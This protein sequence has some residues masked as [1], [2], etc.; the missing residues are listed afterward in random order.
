[1][2]GVKQ[3]G[4]CRWYVTRNGQIFGTPLSRQESVRRRADRLNAEARILVRSCLS[5]GTDF[6]SEGA[7][8][9]MCNPCRAKSEDWMSRM[10][11]SS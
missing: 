8:N 6:K 4:A 1:M 3:L 2:Y 7:H 10:Q 9:R 5:C 11:H